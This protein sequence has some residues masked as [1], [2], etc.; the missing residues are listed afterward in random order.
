MVDPPPPTAHRDR[1]LPA[2][3][4]A[5]L[6]MVHGSQESIMKKSL[7]LAAIAAMLAA[8]AQTGTVGTGPQPMDEGTV[9][10]ASLGY[11]GPPAPQPIRRTN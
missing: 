7:A 1:F 3:P 2:R 9:I 11:H 8:C 4:L 10:A 5:G 6:L